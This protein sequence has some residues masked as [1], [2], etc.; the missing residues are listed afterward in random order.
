MKTVLSINLGNFGSTGGI[1]RG[2]NA[3]AIKKG[4]CAYLAYPWDP[5]NG[6]QEKND[7]IIGSKFGRRASIALGRFTGFN[8]CFSVFATIKF[9][10]RID[11]IKPDIIH[12]HNLHN[13]Y[14]NLPILF[15][16]IKKK[17]IPVIWTLHDCWAFTGK[18]PYFSLVA[19]DKWKTG[20]CECPQVNRYP[21]M[22]VDRSKTMWKLKNKCFKGIENMT[23]VTPSKWLAELIKESYLKDYPVQVINNG[24][25][26]AVFHPVASNVRERLGITEKYIVLGVAF[27]WGEERKGLDIFIELANLLSNDYQ[28]V[29]V[30]TND[31][32]D[33]KLPNNVISIHRTKNLDELVAIY[34]SA[35]LFLNTTRED[36]YPTVN[37]EAL[38]CGT[39]VLT[40]DTGGSPEVINDSCGQIVSTNGIDET[41]KKIIQIRKKGSCISQYCMN[42]VS[43]LD[44]TIKFCE[45][46]EL[47]ERS[48][49]GQSAE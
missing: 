39:P 9:L 13:C 30:G 46:V 45:Y 35:D 37:L 4:F 48:M 40:F 25:D 15:N 47:Y 20:C 12:L 41:I 16:Y 19:C 29:L 22:I 38:A 49:R 18:C 10:R 2:I 21:S 5:N 7:I 1:A 34:S 23:I 43:S 26:L 8:D 14:I 17:K 28:I 11:T 27:D 33:T 42:R 44:K 31:E 32:I 6:P 24:I 36:N 3:V